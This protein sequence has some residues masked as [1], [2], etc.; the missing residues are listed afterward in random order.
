MT[1]QLNPAWQRRPFSSDHLAEI[2]ARFLSSEARPAPAADSCQVISF[3]LADK[4]QEEMV[5]QLGRELARQEPSC[6]WECLATDQTAAAGGAPCT[7]GNA[8]CL[9]TSTSVAQVI[10]RTS[11]PVVLSVGASLAGVRQAYMDIKRLSASQQRDIAVLLVGPRDQHAA[12]RYFRKL[13]VGTLRFLDIPLLNLGFLPPT[14]TADQIPQE[15]R[16]QLLNRIGAR[17]LRCGFHN[18]YTETSA[19][20]DRRVS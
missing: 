6:R 9:L 7:G 14:E 19:T 4:A 1:S 17:L 2:S 11:G 8:V 5:R 10:E 13:A 20:G 18:R 3:L 12:W 15:L 16:R